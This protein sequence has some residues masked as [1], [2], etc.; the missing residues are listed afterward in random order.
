M[1]SLLKTI[2]GDP[3]NNKSLIEGA[4]K[5]ID[6]LVFTD[7]EKSEASKE[8]FKLYLAY[9]KATQPQNLARRYLAFTIAGIWA[10]L[11]LL[12]SITGVFGLTEQSQVLITVMSDYVFVPFTGVTAF[13]FLTHA[14]RAAKSS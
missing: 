10:L 6:A 1:L 7:E 8:T 3:K 9:Q 12:I 11:V 2:F 13:Y 14:M 4:K 5:G